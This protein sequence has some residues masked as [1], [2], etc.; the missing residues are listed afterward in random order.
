MP[1]RDYSKE[2]AGVGTA[3]G[4]I[5]GPVGA[6]VGGALGGAVGGLITSGHDPGPPPD[7]QA[8]ISPGGVIGDYGGVMRD[9]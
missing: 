8:P 2:G 1:K 5:W 7:L 4:S 9:P 3:I 6:S